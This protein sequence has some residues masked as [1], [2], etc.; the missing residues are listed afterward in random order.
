[1]KKLLILLLFLTFLAC[2]TEK[3]G[4]IPSNVPEITVKDAILNES[5]L[6]KE[7]NL[8]GKIVTQCAA[9]GCWFYLKDDTGQILV[10]L[11]PLNLGLPQRTG[12][13]AIVNGT[14]IKE[15]TGHI[16]ISAK[17]LMIK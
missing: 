9:T 14:L 6:N 5:Y 7:I 12:K 1:M 11:K 15:H 8:K 4:Y 2:T 3:Y 16:I 10:D 13:T 17:G